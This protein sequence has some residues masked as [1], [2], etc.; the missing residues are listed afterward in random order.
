M[1]DAIEK[2]GR[3]WDEAIRLLRTALQVMPLGIGAALDVQIFD[4][5]AERDRERLVA[6]VDALADQVADLCA[7]RADYVRLEFLDTDEFRYVLREVFTRAAREHRQEKIDAYRAVLVN[8]MHEDPRVEFDRKA[9]FV[10][11]LDRLAPDDL[12]ILK[13]F[14]EGCNPVGVPLCKKLQEV[15]AWCDAL[16]DG[17]RKSYIQARVETMGASGLLLPGPLP[18]SAKATR[19][20][21]PGQKSM[22]L[23]EIDYAG[24]SYCLTELG[25][26]FV[27][28][29]IV[30]DAQP[31]G[32]EQS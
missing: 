24:R 6:F 3:G 23:R 10:E 15:F 19:Q 22:E 29:L 25:L 2:P 14:Y 13:R 1:T 4:R 32:G 8:A 18:L 11:T 27:R 20:H 21:S 5:I 12:R 7:Q 31:G 28:F 26:E 9:F 16:P 17:A 30:S